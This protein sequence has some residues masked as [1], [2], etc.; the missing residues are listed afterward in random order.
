MKKGSYLPMDMVVEKVRTLGG[1]PASSN[2]VESLV[3]VVLD[4][5]NPGLKHGTQSHTVILLPSWES[6]ASKSCWLYS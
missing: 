2:F 4:S 6:P 3:N 1:L 5:V